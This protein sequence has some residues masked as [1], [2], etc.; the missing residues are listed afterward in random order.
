MSELENALLAVETVKQ[1]ISYFLKPLD[2]ILSVLRINNSLFCNIGDENF[3]V[4]W[5]NVFLH[6]AEFL[7]ENERKVIAEFSDAVGKTDCAGQTAL[8]NAMLE[9]IKIFKENALEDKKRLSK[10]AAAL[11]VL[12]GMCVIIL[13][14]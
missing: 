4:E 9:R 12:V 11:P 6:K 3:A 14:I 10:P 7:K 2:S 8:C 5:R 13:F 1:E